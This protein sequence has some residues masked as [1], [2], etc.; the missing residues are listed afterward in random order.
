MPW[1][2]R[3]ELDRTALARTLDRC[4]ET[5]SGGIYI[6]GTTGEFHSMT[7]EQFRDVVETFMRVM[8]RYPDFPVQ[9]GCGG[10]SLSRVKDRIRVAVWNGCSVVQ[11]PLPGWLPLTDNE[12]IAFFGA[13]TE[14][15][16]EIQVCVYDTAGAGRMIGADL[17]VR[18]LGLFPHITGAKITTLDTE[19]VRRILEVRP[20]FVVLGG[21]DN[22]VALWPAGVKSLAAWISYAF[23]KII[24]D[25]FRALECGETKAIAAGSRK[26]EITQ[27]DVKAPARLLG[28]RGGILD[29]LMGLATG[30]LEPVYQ[31]VL[32]PWMSVDPTD[33]EATRSRIVQLLGEEYL[34]SK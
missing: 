27:N 24:T 7:E 25:L 4:V 14:E 5:G 18:L 29:R 32:D 33:V 31:R 17:W 22:L 23:P 3:D 2:D 28:Y 34:F 15:F 10:F 16:P 13:L 8:S 19:L 1:G 20:G 9:I 12:V 30:F 21:E 6:G 11:I 26:M